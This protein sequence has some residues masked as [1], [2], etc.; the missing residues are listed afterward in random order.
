MAITKSL[1]IED[2]NLNSITRIVSKK[3]TAYKDIDLTMTPKSNGDIF[4]KVDAAAVKQAVKNLILTNWYEKPFKPY[5]G[6]NIAGLLFELADDVYDNDI[7]IQVRNA[8]ELYEP[9]AEVLDIKSS[10][11]HDN[12]SID[13]TVVFKIVSTN[14]V[15]ELSTQLNRLR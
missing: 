5:F 15:V 12:N 13:V 14:E 11:S 1:S 10:V 9:R 6:S 2:R 4:K 7:I 3:T 8:I